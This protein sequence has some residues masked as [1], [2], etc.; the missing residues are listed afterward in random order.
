VDATCS[1]HTRPRRARATHCACAWDAKWS[2]QTVTNIFLLGNAWQMRSAYTPAA[3]SP[4]RAQT[5]RTGT[6]TATTAVT[7]RNFRCGTWPGSVPTRVLPSST[8]GLADDTNGRRREQPHV[9][10]VFVPLV[11]LTPE[12]GPTEM[13]RPSV[14]T[15]PLLPCGPAASEEVFPQCP[16]SNVSN[17]HAGRCRRPTWTG[18]ACMAQTR[19]WRLAWTPAATSSMNTAS[20]TAVPPLLNSH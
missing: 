5:S 3:C 20:A 6:W 2:Q 18:T 11:P 12:V 1:H 4:C 13:V 15:A 14:C 7:L 19:R 16:S 9:I 8:L 17:Q 10:N